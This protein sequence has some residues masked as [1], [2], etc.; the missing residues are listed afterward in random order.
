MSGN[1]WEWCSDWYGNYSS[2]SVTDPTGAAT[3]SYRVLRGGCWANFANICRCAN[4]HYGMPSGTGHGVGL[5]L[6]SQ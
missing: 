1:V 5:R 4:R 3:G 2:A 6:V